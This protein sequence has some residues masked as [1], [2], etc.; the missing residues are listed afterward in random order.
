M[1]RYLILFAMLAGLSVRPADAP[2]L[3]LRA[4]PRVPPPAQP[5]LLTTES[6]IGY[7]LRTE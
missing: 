6:G 2:A 3:A 4:A 1:L 5:R 7:R